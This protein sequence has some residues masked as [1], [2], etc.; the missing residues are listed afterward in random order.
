MPVSLKLLTSIVT[1]NFRRPQFQVPVK[2]DMS[3]YEFIL[4]GRK[5]KDAG[6]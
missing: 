3:D 4:C 1:T 6:E 5:L 2:N